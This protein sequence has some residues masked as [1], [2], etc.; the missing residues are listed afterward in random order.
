SDRTPFHFHPCR[1][2]FHIHR[3]FY[4]QIFFQ[5]RVHQIQRRANSDSRHRH[6]NQQSHLLLEWSRTHQVPGFQILRSSSRNRRR[7]TNNASNHQR[8]HCIIRRSPTGHKKY[9]A[10]SHQ[11]RDAHTT[12][13]IGRISQQAADARSHGHKQKTKNHH[14]E[15]RQQILIPSRAR[16]L[17]RIKRQHHPHHHDDHKRAD[18]YAANRHIIV[19][20]IFRLP[21]SRSLR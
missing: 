18:N 6:A 2:R 3:N 20:P 9:R 12:D 13:W 17:D 19:Q 11:R 1:Q 15:S 14:K 10:S 16:A 7:G 4:R 21:P 8:E 5:S